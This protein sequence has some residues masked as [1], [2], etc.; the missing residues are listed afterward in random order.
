MGVSGQQSCSLLGECSHSTSRQVEMGTQAAMNKARV[1]IPAGRA[2]GFS[3]QNAGV[4][5]DLHPGRWQSI[6]V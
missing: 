2:L 4:A 1:R 3:L 6:P 5:D